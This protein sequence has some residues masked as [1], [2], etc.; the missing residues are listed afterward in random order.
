[1]DGKRN[2]PRRPEGRVAVQRYPHKLSILLRSVKSSRRRVQAILLQGQ[3]GEVLLGPRGSP[4]VEGALHVVALIA[5]HLRNA[6]DE[7]HERL[8]GAPVVADADL[9]G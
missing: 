2:R 3:G 7:L 5:D 8:P 9:L 6:Q 1:M 4:G